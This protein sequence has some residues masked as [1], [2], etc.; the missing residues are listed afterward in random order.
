VEAAKNLMRQ[1]CVHRLV[2]G[3]SLGDVARALGVDRS[4]VFRWEEGTNAPLLSSAIRYAEVLGM[5]LVLAPKEEDT[6][7]EDETESYSS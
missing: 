6:P 5:E 2:L 3:L 7:P 1:L 4:A